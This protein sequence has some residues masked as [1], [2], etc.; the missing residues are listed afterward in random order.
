MSR[1]RQ[2]AVHEREADHA[3]SRA[4]H[5]GGCG[6]RC[7]ACAQKIGKQPRPLDEAVRTPLART[8]GANLDAVRVRDDDSAARLRA[9]AFT[10]GDQIAFAPG[11]YRPD[12]PGGHRLLAHE[13]AH[14][15][16][17]RPNPPA[18]LTPAPRGAVQRNGDGPAL[19]ERA[20]GDAVNTISQAVRNDDVGGAVPPLRDRTL[21]ERKEIRRRVLAETNTKLE[22]W[23]VDQINHAS[24]VDTVTTIASM[25]VGVPVA[26]RAASAASDDPVRNG[27][28]EEGI[29]RV[30]R[31]APLIDRLEVYD[32]GFRE[33]EQAQLDVIRSASAA[34]K[35]DAV[36]DAAER[37]RLDAVLS[38]MNAREEFD[39]RNLI[40]TDRA[41]RLRTAERM[42]ALGDEDPLYDAILALDQEPR[43]E[44][45]M[46]THYLE[47]YHLLYQ[48]QLDI[49]A[50]MVQGTEVDALLARL[51]L[52]TEGR[53]DDQEGVTAVVTRAVAL[54]RERRDLR[55]ALAGHNVTGDARL[56]A[57]ARLRQLDDLDRLLSFA[58]VGGAELQAG[59]VMARL[60]EARGGA[61][62]FAADAERLAEFSRP[63]DAAEYA[64]Q[65][66]KQRILIAGADME[67]MR[68]A[69][70]SLHAPRTAADGTALS[71]AQQQ[72]AD[73]A[74]RN[75]LLADAQ[76][77]DRFRRLV[78]SEQDQVRGAV[79]STSFNEIHLRLGNAFQGGRY[80]EFFHL[81][82]LIARN[83]AWRYAFQ[84]S[85]MGA[86]GAASIYAQVRDPER[87]IMETILATRQM[88]LT[89]LLDYTGNVATLT[90]AFDDIQEGDRAQ[91]RLGWYLTQHPPI[92]PPTAAEADRNAAAIALYQRFATH[93]RGSQTTWRFFYDDSGAQTVL[94]AT[95][96]AEPTREELTSPEGR[97]R[98]ALFWH[99][100]MD[101]R[102]S[103]DRGASAHFTETDETMVAAGREFMALW[104]EVGARGTLSMIDFS[105]LATLH[106]R[107]EG[108][109]GE[110]TE[111]S[112]AVGEMAGMIAATVAGVAIVAATGGAATPGV[113]AVAAAAGGTAR[114]VTRE[115]FGGDYY[116]ALS[117]QGARDALLGA[118]DAALAVVGGELASRGAQLL[119]LGGHALTGG[120]A[121]VAGEVAE[122][123]TRPLARRVAASAVESALD[124]AFS[125]AVSEAFGALTDE[126]TWRRGIMD[127][128]ARVGQAALLG[129]LAG[130]G[131]GAVIGAVLPVA[132]AGGRWL[133][134]A[135]AGRSVETT[136]E[137]AGASGLLAEARAAAR[138]GRVEEANAIAARL[139]GH[140]NAE[141]ITALRQQLGDEM[142]A[143]LRE[144]AGRARISEAEQALLDETRSIDAPAGRQLENELEIVRHSDPQPSRDGAYLDEV[145][146]GN[147]HTWRRDENGWCRFTTKTLCGT[148]IPGAPPPRRAASAA[149]REVERAR[150]ATARQAAH[151][152]ARTHQDVQMLQSELLDVYNKLRRAP[153]PGPR[154]DTSLLEEDERL[155]LRDVFG[156]EQ[157]T[158]P[159]LRDAA[160]PDRAARLIQEL[161]GRATAAA[162]RATTA[163][164]PLA[165][166]LRSAIKTRT[167]GIRE[168]ARSVDQLAHVR[169]PSGALAVDHI[170]PLSDI[171][172]H[173][174]FL[175]LSWEDQVF[176]AGLEDNLKAI[177]FDINHIRG[178]RPWADHA[179]WLPAGH[180]YNAT[181]LGE[182]VAE[183]ARLRAWIDARITA[184]P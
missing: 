128:L 182:I 11:R 94:G 116:A 162:S 120:A 127:G 78:G 71:A 130:L 82:L 152:A 48:W 113:I 168:A 139:E 69:I 13:V 68:T 101:A 28:A 27:T 180:P 20:V 138:A 5:G 57:E 132:G 56:E 111:A 172:N 91:L 104:N 153:L 119:G 61:E 1:V 67:S 62:A 114:V 176:L 46:T 49:L 59:T 83:D 177:D 33:I 87:P 72:V 183:E 165:T 88:P 123:A 129:G 167:D 37:A 150:A 77:N 122:Q 124:G 84:Q 18:G 55:A 6:C 156:T 157:P 30:W 171:M 105:S 148:Q 117:D 42:L 63:E 73:E 142:R 134:N 93:L 136:L 52:A 92:G 38:H 170:V 151:S 99:D 118:V 112:N 75:R 43:R 135:V 54:L 163:E 173:P 79:T 64:F 147:G 22:H 141:E 175:S 50:A 53:I 158:F 80:G 15:L 40:D 121:R 58:R 109:V 137:R 36:N 8:L 97:Y 44:F 35:A 81:V 106:Q 24:T 31:A 149:R 98:A 51:R 21:D 146:L 90:A 12:T 184:R 29:R 161:E 74:L 7:A 164:Q 66:A 89:D 107:F 3:A 10:Q 32:E 19:D 166:R 26:A 140:L 34:E 2:T 70:F 110:F 95:L 14:T 45:V 102:L 174:G 179:S 131:G 25:L 133:W 41:G 160:D 16:Q 60:A 108:R 96:G 145:D 17:Q 23:F 76:V 169:A 9:A 181:Q 126:R 159:A 155:L 85:G 47:L 125:G 100:Q 143:V 39:A 65:I 154:V 4:G 144:P 178:N 115:M 103:L 86:I